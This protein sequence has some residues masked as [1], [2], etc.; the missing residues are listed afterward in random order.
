MEEYQQQIETL[1]ESGELNL[2]QC[3]LMQKLLDYGDSL[4]A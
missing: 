3:E 1:V 2:E 4:L